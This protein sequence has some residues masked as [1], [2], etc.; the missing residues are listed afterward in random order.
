M[1]SYINP[2]LDGVASAVVYAS[3]LAAETI[4]PMF[5]GRPSAETKGV[6]NRLGLGDALSWTGTESR[7]WDDVVLVDCHHPAQLPHIA[8]LNDVSVVIDH[9]PDGDATAFPRASIQNEVVGAAATLVAERISTSSG[10]SSLDPA[11]AAL[12]AAAIASNT[13]DFAA[14][15]TTARDQAAYESLT[16]IAEPLVSLKNLREAMREWRQDFLSISIREAIEKDCKMI[17]TA[18]GVIAVS[19]V[20]GDDARLLADD[21]DIFDQLKDAVASSNADAGLVSLVDTAANTTTLVTT[22]PKVRRALT[23]LNPTPRR[24]GVMLLPFIALRKTH[25]IPAIKS[26]FLTE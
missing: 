2:D 16:L 6:I 14:P 21:P 1:T 20:E 4:H 11:H 17:A 7:E 15:S 22:D 26:Y 5:A 12:L 8:N 9:H 24:E 18:Q 10:S 23:Q 3:H 25:I 13:L 19:Q